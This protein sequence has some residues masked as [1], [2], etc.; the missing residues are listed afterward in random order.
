MRSLS[1]PEANPSIG[2]EHGQNDLKVLIVVNKD[3]EN[4]GHL[5][6]HVNGSPKE[7]EDF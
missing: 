1:L 6:H 4:H 3:G 5:D 2:Q 7:P